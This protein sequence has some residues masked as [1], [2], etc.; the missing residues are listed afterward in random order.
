M[1]PYFVVPPFLRSFFTCGDFPSFLLYFQFLKFRQNEVLLFPLV[2]H[3]FIY[4][5]TSHGEGVMGW[6]ITL[7]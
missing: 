2:H 6:T 7:F 4:L 5:L 1:S 3:A